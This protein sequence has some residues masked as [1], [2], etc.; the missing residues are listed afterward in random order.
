MAKIKEGSIQKCDYISQNSCKKVIFNV[1]KADFP[2]NAYTDLSSFI[3]SM[4]LFNFENKPNYYVFDR[5]EF[6]FP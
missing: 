2:L 1:T 6:S 5:H 4:L 3:L